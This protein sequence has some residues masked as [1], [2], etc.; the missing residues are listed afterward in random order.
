MR[1]L[2]KI[3]DYKGIETRNPHSYL[4]NLFD[5]DQK[6]YIWKTLFGCA[7]NSD[8]SQALQTLEPRALIK[9]DL[10]FIFALKE[11]RHSQRILEFNSGSGEF[12]FS[13]AN[14]YKE[15]YF[16]GLE[17]SKEKLSYAK[18]RHGFLQHLDFYHRDELDKLPFKYDILI[19]RS[20]VEDFSSLYEIFEKLLSEKGIV[21]FVDSTLQCEIIKENRALNIS[22]EIL[23]PSIFSCLKC[24]EIENAIHEMVK[25]IS[26]S[27]RESLFV[28]SHEKI[29]LAHM[30]LYINEWNKRNNRNYL[31]E[32]FLYEKAMSWIQQPFTVGQTKV[33]YFLAKKA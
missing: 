33:K 7:K 20:H 9:S 30:L 6:P 22:L 19:V 8:I 23:R 29:M 18:S 12:L 11:M 16:T 17:V 14:F 4:H 1:G 3:N 32:M 25:L 15:K 26:V 27:E 31:D 5:L 10:D 2:N 24:G 13:L 21:I 28:E